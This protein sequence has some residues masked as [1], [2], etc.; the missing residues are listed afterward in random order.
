V[1]HWPRIAHPPGGQITRSDGVGQFSG[2]G[3]SDRY[4]G[5]QSPRGQHVGTRRVRPAVAYSIS[6]GG[7]SCARR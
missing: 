1:R 3:V 2:D 5:R 6:R 4:H 7:I